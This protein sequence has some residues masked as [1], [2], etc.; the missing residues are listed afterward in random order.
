MDWNRGITDLD[1]SIGICSIE[2]TAENLSISQGL[3]FVVTYFDRRACGLV[4]MVSR[5]WVDGKWTV[6]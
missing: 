5:S 2:R 6:D 4:A 3:G 1:L